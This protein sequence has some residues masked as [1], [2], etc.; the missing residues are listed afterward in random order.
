M[1]HRL[2]L[3]APLLALSAACGGPPPVAPPP[4]PRAR[5]CFTIQAGGSALRKDEAQSLL[6]KLVGQVRLTPEDEALRAPKSL[7]DVRA[8]LKRDLVY[9]Y[10]AGA[11]YA[12]SLG[13]LEGRFVEA[14]LELLLG[15]AMLIASQV[16]VDEEA[17]VGP[18]LRLARASLAGEGELP[19]TDRGRMLAQLIAAAEEG[20]TLENA[21]GI[22][23]PIHVARGAALVRSLREEAPRDARTAM[24]LAEYHRM[25]GE[26][27][28]F[29]RAVAAAE[30]VERAPSLCYLRAMEQLER[31]RNRSAAV[32]ALRGCLRE[33]PKFVRA[34]AALVLAADRPEDLA[35]EIAQLRT[36]D[37]DHYLVML[38]APTLAADEEL[39]RM[40]GAEGKGT[41]AAR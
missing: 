11:A 22:V 18:H 13:T 6:A 39:L 30:S 23:A 33:R 10:P 31:Y 32:A 41:D 38:L 7:Q 26:W 36:M 27:G 1:R 2:A 9:F 34:Q 14:Q 28:E 19:T 24:L 20:N 37:E 4:A 15:D 17:W 12:R 5:P 35:R 3:V 21:L 29:E 8:M 25:R 16:L 40:A